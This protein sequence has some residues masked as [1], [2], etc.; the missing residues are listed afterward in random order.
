M[1]SKKNNN[2]P[3]DRFYRSREEFTIVGLTGLAGSGCSTL[4]GYMGDDVF[5]RHRDIIRSPQSLEIKGV[6]YVN[7]TDLYH[8]ADEPTNNTAVGKLVF[9]RKYSICY[10]FIKQ[11]Y[12]AYTIIKYTHVEWLYVLL[13]VAKRYKENL[14]KDNLIKEL[15]DI[16]F[17]KFYP[18]RSVGLDEKYIE[19][20]KDQIPSDFALVL[21]ELDTIPWD[22]LIKQLKKFSGSYF[23]GDPDPDPSEDKRLLSDFFF[24]NE[25]STFVKVITETLANKDYYCLCF[26]YHRLAYVIRGTGDPTSSATASF[27]NPCYDTTHLYDLIGLINFIIKGKRKQRNG[28]REATRIVIDSIRNSMEALFLKERFTAFY[29]MAVH[30]DNRDDHLKQKIA[31]LFGDDKIEQ[32]RNAVRI[33]DL[34]DKVKYLTGVEVSNDDYEAGDFSGPNVG[35]CISDAEIHITNES[36][37]N[38]AIPRFNTM[39]EQWMKYAALIMHPGLVTPSTEERCMMMAYTAK[40]N[41]SCLARQVG[42]VITNKYHSIRTIGWNEVPFGQAPCGLR[43]ARDYLKKDMIN[44]QYYDYMYSGFERDGRHYY[45]DGHSFVQNLVKD[46]LSYKKLEDNLDGLPFPYC[47]RTLHNRYEGNKNQVYTRSLHAEENAILQMAKFGGESLK[48][49]IIYVTASPCELCSKKLYQ[50]GVRQIVYIDPYP[51]IARQQIISAGY[52]RPQLKLF[53]GA[54][55]ATYFKLFMPFMPMK[56]ELSIRLGLSQTKEKT[57]DEIIDEAAEN[58]KSKYTDQQIKKI[59]KK[60]KS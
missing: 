6:Q 7:N 54:Y 27:T 26:F 9:K 15:S 31:K 41:S 56:D 36:E 49:G 1:D 51:G 19:L 42:A 11:N 45:K 47:F 16:L 22:S 38:Q 14:N 5:Y 3:V 40:L 33:N 46:C 23:V 55:G 2:L 32:E 29:L 60:L 4:A 44:G 30:D 18:S 43:D 50:I 13:F 8:R 58:I 12:Q 21:Y 34:F 57:E 20:Y 37:L 59:C 25:F 53:Q 24:G 28:H 48:D 52:K 10:N 35:Q 39:A 17:D